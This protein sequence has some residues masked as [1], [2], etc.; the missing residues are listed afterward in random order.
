MANY[1]DCF[2]H[3]CIYFPRKK[4][5][6]ASDPNVKPW[7]GFGYMQVNEGSELIFDVPPGVVQKSLDYDLVIRHEHQPDS[8]NT[9]KLATVELLDSNY[10]P[11]NLSG[12]CENSTA[13]NGP[14]EFAMEPDV[15][16][17]QIAPLCL[18]EGQPYYIKFTFDNYDPAAPDR[19]KNIYIDSVSYFSET[20]R[21]YCIVL[22]F[23]SP[24]A[25]VSEL[26]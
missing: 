19:A 4:P 11:F 2:N 3:L 14:I 12:T 7:T 6:D 13:E 16:A 8:P 9:W 25:T 5:Y 20:L 24:R 22:Y 26:Y 1:F 21:L 23:T 18:E 15:T 10:Q 17:T